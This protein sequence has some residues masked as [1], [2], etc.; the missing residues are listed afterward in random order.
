MKTTTVRPIID[1][2]KVCP[3]ESF[4]GNLSDDHKMGILKNALAKGYII[5]PSC[6]NEYASAFI[7]GV[8]MQYN[9]T[10]YQTWNDVTNKSR[11]ELFID[12]IIHYFT[13]NM[14]THYVPNCEPSEPA[15]NTYKVITPCTMK[16]LF[17]KCIHMLECG[18]A[19][20]SQTVKTIT[21][22]IIEYCGETGV[23]IDADR[24]ANRE[25][26]VIL[27]DALGVLP[28]DGVKLFAHIIYKTT[29]LTM[30]VKNRE[31][32]RAIQR[33]R[34][35]SENLWK[36]L[37]ENQK[38]TLAG[39]FNRYKMLF[40]EFKGFNT[41]VTTVINQ[42]GRLSK[43]HH[44]PMKRG[45]WETVLTTNVPLDEISKRA[46]TTT[47]YKLIQVM[48]SIR[49][50]LIMA[51][52]LGDN[53]YVIRN[54]KVFVKE[55]DYNAV[56]S[57]Y[58]YW[59]DIYKICKQQ[60]VLNLSKKACNVRFPKKFDLMCPTSE[61]NFIG[62]IPMGTCCPLGKNTV[63]GIYWKESW[64]T[65]DFDLS[66]QDINGTRYGWNSYY[67]ANDNS[68]VYSGDMTRAERGAN[69]CFYIK[70]N[71]KDGIVYVNRYNGDENSKFRLFFGHDAGFNGFDK[72]DLTKP[73]MVDRNK[74]SI[75]SEVVQGEGSE[76][77]VGA[78]FDNKMYFFELTCGYRRVANAIAMANYSKSKTKVWNTNAVLDMLKKK[79]YSAI[80]IKEILLEAGFTDVTTCKDVEPDIDL[81]VLSRDT[82]IDLFDKYSTDDE[83]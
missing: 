2:F 59:E 44:K 8:D 61:K 47:N 3:T 18:I 6:L 40:L 16:E 22:F 19:L 27:C 53:M 5:H 24:I 43:K 56:D 35:K 45:F 11:L 14:D 4:I 50:R 7:T 32:R 34:E 42:I 51:S 69:E 62:D 23:T 15:W 25:A 12:Q 55:N 31:T 20:K 83:D 75:E 52:G 65:R 76:Q 64:G 72:K 80:P 74:I 46:C 21:D 79:A 81:T 63:F 30:I 49:E 67:A 78:I 77:M 73:Y 26:L 66:Y 39:V 29:G 10:F 70:N 33:G 54:G 13:M 82:L 9:S 71:A 36:S 58:F 38:I 28:N 17:G 68:I 1:L 48:Q 57:R 41:K 60:L 37:N